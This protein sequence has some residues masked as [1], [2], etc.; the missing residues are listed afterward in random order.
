VPIVVTVCGEG[1][2]GGALGIAVG[3][4]V[5]MQEFA[6]YSVIPPEGCAAILWRDAGRKVEAARA[7]KITAPDLLD[8][9]LIDEIVKEPIG[10]AHLDYDLAATLVGDAIVRHLDELRGMSVAGR[11][12]ARYQ[13]FRS[14]GRIGVTAAAGSAAAGADG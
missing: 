10:G 14:M 13:K 1:G 9:G 2:S 5:L 12:E 7:L 8:L 3:D 11:L 6:V 4:R